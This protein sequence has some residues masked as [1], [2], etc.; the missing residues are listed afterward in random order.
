MMHAS[1]MPASFRVCVAERVK[2]SSRTGITPL[3][4]T[5]ND[6]SRLA[7]AQKIDI[8]KAGASS[9]VVIFICYKRGVGVQSVLAE[10]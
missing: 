3:A 7:M 9:F 8:F 6:T 5:A 4:D 10:V 1:L 2:S